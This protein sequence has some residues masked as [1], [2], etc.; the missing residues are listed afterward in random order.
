MICN[1]CGIDKPLT[2]EFF[3]VSPTSRYGFR[4]DC[5]DCEAR[6][7]REKWRAD[8]DH[9]RAI[10]RAYV[11]RLSDEEREERHQNTRRW[12]KEHHEAHREHKNRANKK[13]EMKKK[14]VYEE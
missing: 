5:R 9:G 14:G 6:K 13:R 4:R 2:D 8:P 12:Q 7:A 3:R 1:K 10:L 11:D